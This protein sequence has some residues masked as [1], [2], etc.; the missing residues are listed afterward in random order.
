MKSR[1]GSRRKESVMRGGLRSIVAGASA[2]LA[3]SSVAQAQTRNDLYPELATILASDGAGADQFGTVMSLDGDTLAVGMPLDDIGTALDQG[4]VRIFVRSGATWSLQA[5]LTAADGLSA[6]AFGSSVALSGDTLAVGVPLDDVGTFSNQGSVRIFVRSGTTWTAQ[7][8]LTASDGA[9]FDNF[10]ASVSFD[11][12][13]LAVGVPLDD[14]GTASNQGSVRI[15]TRTG[16]TAWSPQATVTASDGAA[17]DEFGF[18]I[19]LDGGT[20]AVG[21]PFDRV[22]TLVDAGSVRVFV[23]DGLSWPAE[24]TLTMGIGN[25]AENDQFGYSLSLDGN[26]L[27]V[28]VPFDDVNLFLVDSGSARIFVRSGSVWSVQQAL[29][30]SAAAGDL[31]GL[32]VSL[33]NNTLA[34]G[35]PSA[36]VGANQNQGSVS[37]FERSGAIWTQRVGLTAGDGTPDDTVGD[38]VSLSGDTLAIGMPFDDVGAT[39]A[40][41]SVRI[42]GNYRVFNDTT[43]VGFTSLASAIAGSTAGSR[44][45]VGA[46]AFAEADGIIDASQKRFNFVAVEPIALSSTALMTVATN[47]VFERSLDVASAGLTVNGDLA[48]PLNGTVTF[49]QLSVGTG[50]QF[51]QRG[52]TVLVNQ[53]LATTSGGI[54]YLQGPVLAEAVTTAVGAQNRCAGDTDVF[55]NYTNAG[56]TVVQRGILY[57]YGT[58]TN[59]GTL[60][61]QVDTSYLPPA[62]GD[63]Y[64]VGGDYAVGAASSIVLPDPVWWLRVGGSF[65]MAIDSASRFVMDAATLEMTGVGDSAVQSLEVFGR[66]LG[67]IGDGFATTNFPLGALRIRAGANVALEDNHNNAPG[68]TAEAIYTNELFV[69]AGA[70]LTTNGYRI[71][72][73]AATIAGTVSNPAD[74]IVVPDA[75]PCPAD[76]FPNG[77]VDAADLGI[78]LSTWGPCRGACVADLDGDGQVGASDLAVVLASWGPCAAN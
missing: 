71:Y 19:C 64:S 2:A 23:R 28:G 37:V 13:T 24:A 7:A 41:G 20:L 35:A 65:D 66:D 52:S 27:A 58:L 6:D 18:S 39:F 54:C 62:P 44:L 70:T 50:G 42:F 5:T 77:M 74:I 55:A 30:A 22:G 3:L 47:T 43:N 38:S 59:T 67:A 36:N 63:G 56:T 14:V 10:G 25:E 68:K 31:F 57:I 69:P 32:S 9:A 26:T 11:A 8:T 33:D 48:A 75:P 51:L 17:Q 12:E 73:R 16:G 40:Q 4:S 34:V 76:L 46:P 21:V 45:I 61:G 29:V 1:G 49:E 72:T 60:T 78:L 15:F 53:N